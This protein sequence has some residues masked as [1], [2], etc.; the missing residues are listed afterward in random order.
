M[1]TKHLKCRHKYLLNNL[2]RRS[3]LRDASIFSAIMKL[4]RALQVQHF[5]SLDPT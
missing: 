4:Q 5:R 2:A 1:H 3:P